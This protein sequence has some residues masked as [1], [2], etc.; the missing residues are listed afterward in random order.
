MLVTRES[1]IL[2]SKYT[3]LSGVGK[4]RQCI[5]ASVRLGQHVKC[6]YQVHLI[7]ASVTGKLR[8]GQ[9]A[10]IH[11]RSNTTFQASVPQCL[12]HPGAGVRGARAGVRP[13]LGD[14]LQVTAGGVGVK[15]QPLDSDN[16]MYRMLQALLP[17]LL[18]TVLAGNETNH[19]FLANNLI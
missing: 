7:S 5:Y 19:L 13:R 4:M 9:S 6:I 15:L 1:T 2:S 3:H 10:S 11:Y 17:N 14:R 12:L 16:V 18:G 8:M